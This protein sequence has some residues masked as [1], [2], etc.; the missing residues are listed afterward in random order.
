MVKAS[1]TNAGVHS[2]LLVFVSQLELIQGETRRR[3]EMWGL[4][5]RCKQGLGLSP[6]GRRN[7][8]PLSLGNLLHTVEGGPRHQRPRKVLKRFNILPFAWRSG[9][10]RS[11]AGGETDS[12]RMK[13]TNLFLVWGKAKYV[14]VLLCLL[15]IKPD[16]EGLPIIRYVRPLLGGEDSSQR[17]VFAGWKESKTTDIKLL[18]AQWCGKLTWAHKRSS[19]CDRLKHQLEQWSLRSSDRW[20]TGRETEAGHSGLQVKIPDVLQRFEGI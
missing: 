10:D 12:N 2:M 5:H 20:S 19:P 13:E 4:D 9:T 7:L 15:S 1:L 17:R 6:V 14:V 3:A 11:Q 18:D 16:V 8:L